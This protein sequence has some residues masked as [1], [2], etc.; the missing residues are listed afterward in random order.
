MK[1]KM[2]IMFL[3]ILMGMSFLSFSQGMNEIQLNPEKVKMF[4]PYMQVRH[5]GVSGLETWKSTN[6][7]LYTKEMW[8]YSESFYV[9]RNVH[10]DGQV[11]DPSFIDISRFESNRKQDEEVVVDMPGFKD[12]LVLIPASKLIYKP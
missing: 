10:T 2:K 3:G 5:G 1:N 9:K 7:L 8:Y 11:L 4:T 6:K 12:A